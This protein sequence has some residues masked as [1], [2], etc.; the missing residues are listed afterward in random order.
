LRKAKPHIAVA[1]D[2][3]S[4][5]WKYRINIWL[6]PMIYFYTKSLT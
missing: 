5:G 2:S 3:I 6:P 4:C 1:P